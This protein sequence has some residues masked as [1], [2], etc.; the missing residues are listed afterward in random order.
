MSTAIRKVAGFTFQTVVTAAL[1]LPGAAPATPEYPESKLDS[2]SPIAHNPRK[3][4][5][6]GFR[7]SNTNSDGQTRNAIILYGSAGS[8]KPFTIPLEKGLPEVSLRLSCYTATDLGG[9]GT[10]FDVRRLAYVGA[11]TITLFPGG[12]L[13]CSVIKNQLRVK[14]QQGCKIIAGT[15]M[16]IGAVVVSAPL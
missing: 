9:S 14:A 11:D 16:N 7:S 5:F 10:A 8:D 2:F 12:R 3:S 15:N 13:C 1:N 6:G 4:I